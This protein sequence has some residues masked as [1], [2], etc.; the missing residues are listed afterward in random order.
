M[1]ISI[2]A[3]A[4]TT[5]RFYSTDS[6]GNAESLKTKTYNI[7]TI[8][9]TVTAFTVPETSNSLI[10]PINAFTATDDN[11][12]V[13]A[14]LITESDLTPA[15]DAAGWSGA[16]QT[17]YVFVTEG[18]KNLFAWAK[19][20]VGNIS[21]SLTGTVTVDTT[22]PIISFTD[23]VAA[24]PL[25]SDT[26]T[27]DWGD[28]TI[29]KWDYDAD[30]TCS[31]TAGDYSKTNLNALTQNTET[32]NAQFI[33]LYGE[34]SAG[35]ITALV[36]ANDINI[37]ITPPVIT[38]T[39]PNSSSAQTKTIT[40]GAT[41]SAIK[42]YAVNTSGVNTCNGTLAFT[43]YDSLIFTSEADNGKKVCYKAEDS[44]GNIAYLLSNA[45]AG[46]DTVS[47]NATIDTHPDA[48]TNSTAAAFT[49]SASETADL[50]CK[51]DSD[52]YGSCLTPKN[53]TGLIEGN[54]TFYVKAIDT[55]GNVDATPASFAFTVDITAPIL[56]DLAPDNQTF[57]VTTTSKTLTLDTTETATCKYATTSGTAYAAMT[58]F[59]STDSAS[60]STFISGLSSGTTYTY[61]LKCQDPAGNTSNE[62]SLSFTI[63]PEVHRL[64]LSSVKV[65]LNRAINN[66]KDTFHLKKNRFKLQGED[67]QLANGTVKLYIGGKLKDTIDVD[68]SGVWKV[69]LKFKDGAKKSLKLKFFDSY[70]TLIDTA[71]AKVK[72][73]TEKPVFTLFPPE[74]KT[75]YLNYIRDE[76]R[77]LVFQATDNQK[78]DKYKIEFNGRIQVKKVNKS[79]TDEIQSF[80]VP[81]D[82]LLGIYLFTVTAYDKAGNTEK[83]EAE[84]AVR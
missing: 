75:V 72:I 41:E 23:N 67:T 4:T 44:A 32:N 14:Y 40:A 19:D 31:E 21:D 26:I 37:D 64:S 6:N 68:A 82:T 56:S 3:N 38:I 13:A 51:M 29:R 53:Y 33:C 84:V 24:G 17:T 9:P 15:V 47:P 58:D 10:V 66:F 42:S 16:A 12:G 2:P 60:H 81:K 8:V 25:Q 54:H 35:N 39:N 70:G 57:S 63:A 77:A 5:L 30:G 22:P 61:Y 48:L 49:F 83:R 71:K 79:Q 34:D 80:L 45:I 73:D 78:V 46:I 1:A 76:N 43:A 11:T 36:S 28:A 65:K 50:Q 20:A 69:A 55:A 62:S 59:D 7:D 18:I 52:V 74:G 27:A